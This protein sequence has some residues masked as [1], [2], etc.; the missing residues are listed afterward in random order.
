MLA[1]GFTKIPEVHHVRANNTEGELLVGYFPAGTARATKEDIQKRHVFGQDDRTVPMAIYPFITVG[2]V[3]LGTNTWCTGTLVGPRHVLTARHCLDPANPAAMRFSPG[4]DRGLRNGLTAGVTDIIVDKRNDSS[5]ACTTKTDY[6]VLVI[7]KPLGDEV[8]W[9]GVTN[10]YPGGVGTGDYIHMGYPN[11]KN[12][13]TGQRPWC[14]PGLLNYIHDAFT[15]DESG[16]VW[17][18]SDNAPGQSGG[19]LWEIDDQ[20]NPSMWGDLSISTKTGP[21]E[22]EVGFASGNGL[23]NLVRRALAEY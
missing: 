13:G 6:A 17:T 10:T 5:L 14:V 2:R 18:M 9:F 16:P 23:Q 22:G 3:E 21:D 8:G 12:D 11:D 15:C 7:D 19:P 20:G 1:E 4:Y